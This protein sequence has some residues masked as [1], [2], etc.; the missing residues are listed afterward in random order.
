[1]FILKRGYERGKKTYQEISDILYDYGKQLE[2]K[3]GWIEDA[4]EGGFVSPDM[5]TI[6]YYSRFPYNGQLVQFRGTSN[7]REQFENIKK[8]L[9]KD[10]IEIER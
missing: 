8:K 10:F 6:Y 9:S 7:A 2:E 4:I 5:S 1:M 3:E